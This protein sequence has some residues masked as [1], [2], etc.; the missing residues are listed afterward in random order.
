MPTQNQG[1]TQLPKQK[2][3]QYSTANI[4]RTAHHVCLSCK[5][6]SWNTAIASGWLRTKPT[7]VV[8]EFGG[9]HTAV[10]SQKLPSRLAAVSQ[11]SEAVV[12]H[13]DGTDWQRHAMAA[14][15][16]PARGTN[17]AS[18]ATTVNAEPNSLLFQAGVHSKNHAYHEN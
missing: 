7:L 17:T 6:K 1:L 5:N 16:A 10:T 18:V 12:S 9:L 4:Q 13:A 15:G 3:K 2:N 14:Y 8:I 11:S